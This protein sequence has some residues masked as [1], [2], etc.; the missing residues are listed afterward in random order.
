MK[1]I[2]KTVW[3]MGIRDKKD[4]SRWNWSREYD[5]FEELMAACMPYLKENVGVVTRIITQQ[6]FVTPVES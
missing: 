2:K 1:P 4:W 3:R 5:S 6:V